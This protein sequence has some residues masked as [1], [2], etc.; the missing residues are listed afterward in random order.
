MRST[1][2]GPLY[3]SLAIITVLWLT[4]TVMLWGVAP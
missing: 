2:L 1:G 3:A 4:F